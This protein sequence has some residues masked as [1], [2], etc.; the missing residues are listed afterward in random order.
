MLVAKLS[1][2]IFDTICNDLSLFG[3]QEKNRMSSNFITTEK[4]SVSHFIYLGLQHF[5]QCCLCINSS[6][7]SK[8]CMNLVNN[9]FFARPRIITITTIYIYKVVGNCC[10]PL[11]MHI[12][13]KIELFIFKRF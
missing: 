7:Q 6:S 12:I 11:C 2:V 10:N 8:P 13:H 1:Q 9:P 4:P 5:F 3:T